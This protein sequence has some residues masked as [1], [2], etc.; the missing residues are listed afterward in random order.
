MTGTPMRRKLTVRL[1]T[2]LS[3]E[4]FN[5]FSSDPC[6][7]YG[8]SNY[9]PLCMA[10]YD[11]IGA[12]VHVLTKLILLFGVMRNSHVIPRSGH[13]VFAVRQPIKHTKYWGRY[14]AMTNRI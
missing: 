11:L 9:N 14:L 4:S 13:T 2:S 7:C 6:Y 3:K 8:S 1:M 12:A 5:L 10:R